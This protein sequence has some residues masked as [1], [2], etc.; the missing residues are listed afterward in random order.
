MAWVNTS[1]VQLVGPETVYPASQVGWQLV[2]STNVVDV[3]VPIFPDN[4]WF[5]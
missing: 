1:A 2:P 5:S 4:G 3:H